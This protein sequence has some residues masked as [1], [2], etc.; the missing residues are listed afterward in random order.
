MHFLRFALPALLAAGSL[1]AQTFDWIN[2]AP[3]SDRWSL[4]ANWSP[5]GPPTAGANVIVDRFEQPFLSGPTL[6]QNASLAN[7]TLTN[8]AFLGAY[9]F[10]DPATASRTLDVTGF[11]TLGTGIV[12]AVSA[13]EGCTYSLGT[14][15]AQSNATLLRGV[16]LG[17]GTGF[18]PE[19]GDAVIQWRGA[20]V[21]R[22]EGS[23]GL[24]PNGYLR[25]QNNGLDA[26]RNLTENGGDFGVVGRSYTTTGSFSNFGLL[27]VTINDFIH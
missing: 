21:V 23:I 13:I 2:V 3:A 19:L 10:G 5:A 4:A 7:L 9:A 15:S 18:H 20:N 8:N 27:S 14:L 11:T 12:N 24:G 16:I 25:D 17:V 1:G 6:D 22:N 26:L